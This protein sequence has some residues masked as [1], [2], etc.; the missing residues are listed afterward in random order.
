MHARELLE[1]SLAHLTGGQTEFA[2]WRKDLIKRRYILMEDTAKY[3]TAVKI[4]T[5]NIDAP[6]TS[7]E[8]G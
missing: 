3:A 5:A 6:I 2:H 8:L 7:G 4:T 1:V